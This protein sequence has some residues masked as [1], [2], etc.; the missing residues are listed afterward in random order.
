M[1]GG[2]GGAGAGAGAATGFAA[3]IL[4]ATFGADF[5]ADFVDRAAVRE[6]DGRVLLLRTG[7]RR[8]AGALFFATRAGLR[9]EIRDL[10]TRRDL[11]IDS[12]EFRQR[13]TGWTVAN[14]VG[15]GQDP[16]HRKRASVGI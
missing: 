12:A 15:S 16:L 11:A 6:A 10:V 14:P 9:A 4:A 7:R 1:T 8:A 3:A 5:G 13:R 2:G